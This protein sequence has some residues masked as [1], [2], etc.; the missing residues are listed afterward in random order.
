M[1]ASSQM[2]PISCS[3][4][5]R[6]IAFTRV[7]HTST[8][9]NSAYPRCPWQPEAAASNLDLDGGSC[10]PRSLEPADRPTAQ[11]GLLGLGPVGPNIGPERTGVASAS[12]RLRC[13]VAT[14]AAEA[15]N[16]A[17]GG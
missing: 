14:P 15:M 8:R 6:V 17:R 3:T 4:M 2:C 10:E 13:Q 5:R 7:V 11:V 9:P 1:F 12:V 16:A